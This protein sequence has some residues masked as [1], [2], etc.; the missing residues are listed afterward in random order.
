MMHYPS[1][2]QEGIGK[3][4]KTA[5]R[6]QVL[7]LDLTPKHPEEKAGLPTTQLTNQTQTQPDV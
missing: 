7:G 2:F 1:I 3:P 6:L 5:V 4:Q